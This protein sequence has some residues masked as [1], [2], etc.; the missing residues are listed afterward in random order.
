MP[1]HKC[2]TGS[3]QIPAWKLN[4]RS[5]GF[6]QWRQDPQSNMIKGA[7][8]F[9][10]WYDPVHFFQCGLE[11]SVLLYF[12][13]L[14]TDQSVVSQRSTQYIA[15]FPV[16]N[17]NHTNIGRTV[18]LV[19]CFGSMRTKSCPFPFN[20]PWLWFMKPPCSCQPSP[21]QNQ[22]YVGEMN[23]GKQP[24]ARRGLATGKLVGWQH[25]GQIPLP[26]MSPLLS[27]NLA[28]GGG[29]CIVRRL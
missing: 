9:G 13:K 12:A 27:T 29:C 5:L 3:H 6:R 16:I 25:S 11:T 23:R 10:V 28:P 18:L 1:L 19:Q 2:L 8:M 14:V 7:I 17:L 15:D 20:K 26:R 24:C 4:G 22:V 21:Q